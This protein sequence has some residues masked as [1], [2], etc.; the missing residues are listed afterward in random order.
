MV[1]LDFQGTSFSVPLY[2]NNKKVCHFP[3]EGKRFNFAWLCFEL[4]PVPWIIALDLKKTTLLIRRIQICIRNIPRQSPDN[5]RE[6]IE[7]RSVVK[8]TVIFILQKLGFVTSKEKHCTE[9][10]RVMDFLGFKINS[11]AK[12]SFLW[13]QNKKR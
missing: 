11:E 7:E 5:W 10:S 12:T 3:V 1:N 8:Y 13:E 9:T 6:A 2:R 4:G